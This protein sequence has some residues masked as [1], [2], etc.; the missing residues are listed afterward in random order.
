MPFRVYGTLCFSAAIVEKR[1]L[2]RGNAARHRRYFDLPPKI[3][4]TDVTDMAE[5]GIQVVREMTISR[6]AN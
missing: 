2:A 1:Q 6:V 4:A 3:H 5:R